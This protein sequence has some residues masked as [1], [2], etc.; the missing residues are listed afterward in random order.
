MHIS[1]YPKSGADKATRWDL[2]GGP[3]THLLLVLA[4]EVPD[5]VF[6]FSDAPQE[7]RIAISAGVDRCDGCGDGRRDGNVQIQGCNIH[8]G[9]YGSRSR[10]DVRR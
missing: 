10:D 1:F 3:P 8:W 5:F 6:K 4:A 7:L 2:D 9:L